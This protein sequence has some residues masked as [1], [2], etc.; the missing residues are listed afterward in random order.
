MDW[1]LHFKINR[2]W[3]DI[4]VEAGPVVAGGKATHDMAIRSRHTK[5]KSSTKTTAQLLLSEL[6]GPARFAKLQET[7]KRARPRRSR[8]GACILTADEVFRQT[9]SED[10]F[11]DASITMFIDNFDLLSSN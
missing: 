1:P 2:R 11:S 6:G 7:Y 10:G 3:H 8:W 9:A 4:R 5:A